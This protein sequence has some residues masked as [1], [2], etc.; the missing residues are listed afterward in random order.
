MTKN[1]NATGQ[2]GRS[3][4]TVSATSGAAA[5]TTIQEAVTAAAAVTP[6]GTVFIFEGVYAES[7]AWPADI[8]VEGAGDGESLFEVTITGNQTFAG[9]GNIS[10]KN[11]RFNASSGDTWTQSAPAG[12]GHIAFQDCR[13]S[14]TSGRG[15]VIGTAGANTSSMFLRSSEISSSLQAIDASG[16][17]I[18]EITQ[19]SLSTSTNN[20]NTVDLAGA[21]SLIT[22]L[23]VFNNSGVGTG[24]CV[25]LNGVNNSVDSQNTR[26]NA[27]NATSASA[28]EFTIAD[29]SIRSVKDEMFIAGGTFWARS[30]GAFGTLSYGSTIINTGTTALIDPQIT[31]TILTTIPASA[32]TWS[33][34][35]ASITV[36]SNTGSVST[37]AITLTL[38]ATPTNG[39]V[40]EF[41]LGVLA[42]LNVSANTGHTIRLGDIVSV[43][44][45]AA[46]TEVLGNR[47]KVV[48]NSTLTSWLATSLIG[49]WRI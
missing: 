30:A 34:Q 7:I 23:G 29:G 15:V 46:S 1:I 42:N 35:G 11:I 2:Y 41:V 16:N 12:S 20:F 40:C 47:L 37:A 33:D 4:F 25:S 13:I 48:F 6:K 26:Y 17:S 43:S 10:F 36:A 28:F 31:S 3:Q 49:N 27:G 14:P 5:Y 21:T 24:S 22:E 38:P 19:S 45:G 18:L 44:A 8:T 9:S 39:D 32:F